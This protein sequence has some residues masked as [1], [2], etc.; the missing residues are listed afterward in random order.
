MGSPQILDFERLLQPIGGDNPAGDNLRADG[1][2]TSVYYQIKDARNA[3]RDAERKSL[4]EDEDS[5]AAEL[6]DWR[7]VL[8]LGPEIIA[9]R[10]KDLEIAAWLIEGLTRRDGFAGLRD[11]FRLVCEMVEQFWEALY[12][13]PDEEGVLTRVA[14]LAGLNGVD[15]HGVLLTPMSNIPVTADT[16]EG[17]FSLVNYQ[18]ALDIDRIE[19]PDKRAQRIDQGWV[20]MQVFMRAVAE[21]P[22]DFFR[23]LLDDISAA[24]E[25]Y[26]RL[27]A[28][29]EERCGCDEDGYDLTPPSSAIR[30]AMQET[31]ET[32]RTIAKHI[33]GDD[34]Q[35]AAAT[36]EAGEGDI[37]DVPGNGVTVA[38]VQSKGAG[39]VATREDA[40]GALLQVAEFFK[41][42]EPHSPVS[43]AL[44]QAVRWGR[45]PLPELW[46]ELIPDDATRDQMYKLVGI[47]TPPE[48]EQSEY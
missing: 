42:T 21:T 30:N 23:D 32:V 40:F 7:P 17:R 1:S 4:F 27:C 18:R 48:E 8:D 3:A 31:E 46:K 37:L 25:E 12:P 20:S 6:P 38:N 2:P 10:S 9:E 5:P 14:P 11:G 16:S 28:A 22:A 47:Q 44:E 36:P 43:Y 39:Q 24:T 45:M 15:A 13:L 19:D 33:L 41:R 26:A 34:E 35:D 29:L